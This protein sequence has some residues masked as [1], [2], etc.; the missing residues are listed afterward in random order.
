[1]HC[2]ISDRGIDLWIRSMG[3]CHHLWLAN[4]NID[5]GMPH[6]QCI[7]GNLVHCGLTWPWREFQVFSPNGRQ[8]AVQGDCWRVYEAKDFLFFPS[9]A[10]QEN[11]SVFSRA[12]KN[13]FLGIAVRVLHNNSNRMAW[14]RHDLER[15]S[16][17]LALCAGNCWPF[18]AGNPLMT[19]GFLA[20]RASNA[21]RILHW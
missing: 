21:I 3:W 16:T 5:W 17:L 7:L 14:W 8:S 15:L 9:K 18:W 20:R 12:I 2:G 6:V 11:E 13:P 1:M 10:L 4:L 19:G